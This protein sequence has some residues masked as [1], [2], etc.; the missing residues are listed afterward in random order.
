MT[1]KIFIPK[2]VEELVFLAVPKLLKPKFQ[3]NGAQ[4]FQF[5]D[6]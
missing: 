5:F 3:K 4:F 1:S 2:I 6:F